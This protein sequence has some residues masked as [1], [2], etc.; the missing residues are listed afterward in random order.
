MMNFE[1]D[2]D[3]QNDSY[4]NDNSTNNNNNISS[5]KTNGDFDDEDND[6]TVMT[7]II[8]RRRFGSGL[9]NLGNT[10]FMNS[11]L[12]CLAHTQP[13]QRY[14]LTGAYVA[15]LNRDNPL[16]TGGELATQF[17]QLLAE[18]W[19]SKQVVVRK[20]NQH[21]GG[22]NND[23][24]TVD[25]VNLWSTS[26][27]TNIVYPKNF[28]YTLGKHAEQFMGYD[29]HDSQELATYLLDALHEDC[30]RVT[31]KPYIEKPEQAD[32]E[33]DQEASDKAW[34]LHLKREDSRVLENFMGQVKS[35]VQCCQRECGRVSTTFDPFMFLSVPIPGSDDRTLQITY[36]PLDPNIRLKKLSV[37]V[38]KMASIEEMLN[39]II[40]LLPKEGCLTDPSV[41][42][43]TEDLEICDIWKKEVFDWI[44]FTEEVEKIRENDDT[45]V[46]QLRPLADVRKIEEQN[47]AADGSSDAAILES[48][49][50]RDLKHSKYYHLDVAT[51][52]RIN[53]GEEWT[54]ELRHYLKSPLNFVNAFHA[55]K[56]S[57]DDRVRIY[58]KLVAFIDHCH[59]AA[60]GKDDANDDTSGQKRTRANDDTIVED[61]TMESSGKMTHFATAAVSNE[62]MTEIID[63]CYA[64]NLFVNVSSQYD[65]AVL[66][67][68]AGKMLK[69][70]LN[71]ER[72]KKDVFPNGVKI[73]L[74]MRK[75]GLIAT[76][77]LVLRIP[78]SMTV[79][80][81]REEIA[82]RL[83][84]SLKAVAHPGVRSTAAA[85]TFTWND[86]EDPALRCTIEDDDQ[87]DPVQ[88]TSGDDDQQQTEQQH[89]M[90]M[91]GSPESWIVRRVPLSYERKSGAG[92]G[93]R[94]FAMNSKQLGSI[95]RLGSH[96]FEAGGCPMS[97]AQSSHDEEKALVAELVGNLG[98]V[99]MD[100]PADLFDEAFDS[101]EYEAV[102]VPV[103]AET[104]ARNSITVLDCIEKFC[105]ME[106]LEESEQWYCSRCKAHVCAWKQFHIYRSPPHLIVHLKR[107]QF[108]ARTHRRQKIGVFIDFPL[109]G[110]DLT[111]QVLHWT[112]DEKPIYDCYA[113]SNHYGGLGG[114]H[115][116]AYA[117]N[118]G[119][120]WCH[121]DDSRI[122]SHVDPSEVVSQAAYVLYYRRRDV[123]VGLDF[124][125]TLPTPDLVVSRPVMIQDPSVVV[126]TKS[127]SQSRE[128]S[129]ISSSA[130]MIDDDEVMMDHTGDGSR[131]TSPASVDV[132][133]DEYNYP[134]DEFS[135]N[136]G[137]DDQ[138]SSMP[139][140]N[141][142]S[143]LPLQ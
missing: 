2:D 89:T 40:E 114:G 121:Y 127:S 78:S 140:N 123:P 31:K 94:S 76:A 68:L 107:F 105:Q 16:G 19:G 91:T 98:Q 129:E 106:Q 9:G 116:T 32:E 115:Y 6:G 86:A 43:V 113:V 63:Q 50:I 137:D 72:Q 77:P 97:F 112:D 56:G 7:T 74:R 15:D 62:P 120:V 18:M 83:S 130:A 33:T 125:M 34:D 51:L 28:K 13:L 136:G 85:S 37:K 141:H 38:S 124:E 108:S 66:E 103:Q 84:R 128:P 135:L 53:R 24:S 138:T 126:A 81:L 29:Q 36:V 58:R 99:F 104:A 10:C 60:Q 109:K 67:F 131:S 88:V 17:A 65:V 95:A 4:W 20:R 80:E 71:M 48:L 93:A 23:G 132:V 61:M 55:R 57:S 70:I 3:N 101:K 30:N 45:V 12:Q 92:N 90:S 64:Y 8:L 54:N 5:E 111:N 1:N 79:F 100:W 102:D 118:D 139:G 142:D 25:P 134:D 69:E 59:R 26:T 47:A 73:E 117:L 41:L 35:R 14:F 119:G 44:K 22:G 52:A 143:S 49:G 42:P 122:T 133:P 39:R 110:L 96:N 82:F 27:A 46:Y 21:G 87:R 11:T 75:H